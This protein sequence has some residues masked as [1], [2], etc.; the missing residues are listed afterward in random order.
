VLEMEIFSFI[1][2]YIIIKC[3]FF[4]QLNE[5]Y[6]SFEVQE[7]AVAKN[8]LYSPSRKVLKTSSEGL[9]FM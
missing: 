4:F 9:L 8:V 7:K 1:E 6:S 2:T 3:D 5:A